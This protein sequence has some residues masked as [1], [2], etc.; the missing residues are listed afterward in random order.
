MKIGAG[1]EFINS[2]PLGR[3]M[4][5]YSVTRRLISSR[6]KIKRIMKTLRPN[7]GTLRFINEIVSARTR[8]AQAKRKFELAEARARS[9]KGSRNGKKQ[10]VRSWSKAEQQAK[11]EFYRAHAILAKWE[12]KYMAAVLRTASK[13]KVAPGKQVAESQGF[14]LSLPINVSLL[15]KQHSLIPIVEH[16][17]L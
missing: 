6:L 15:K 4:T 12:K 8:L 1:I 3:P 10:T 14:D 11:E 7:S 13:Q 9:A 5:K 2:R 16:P 17:K